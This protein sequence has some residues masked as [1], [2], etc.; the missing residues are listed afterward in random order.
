[1][2][3]LGGVCRLIQVTRCS[4]SPNFAECCDSCRDRE[5]SLH[6]GRLH[7]TAPTESVIK[8]TGTDRLQTV[9][10]SADSH[11]AQ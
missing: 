9:A 4:M 3:G 10:A 6:L 2:V 11:R 8:L 5:L 1:M 7:K